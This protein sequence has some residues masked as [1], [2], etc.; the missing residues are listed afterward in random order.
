MQENIGSDMGIP[1][2]SP[3]IQHVV[4]NSMAG[5]VLAMRTGVSWTLI[6]NVMDFK[7]W[8]PGIDDYNSD[9]RSEIGL[10]ED[11][12]LVLQPTRVVSRKGI[13][14][15]IELIQRL[16]HPKSAWLEQMPGSHLSEP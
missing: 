16:G 15:S 5:E 9:F 1:P 14:T 4:I 7:I 8:P 6:S 2:V 10:D 12:L 13:E 11:S 3:N